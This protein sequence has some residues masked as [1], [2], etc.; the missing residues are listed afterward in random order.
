MALP[1]SLSYIGVFRRNGRSAMR[2]ASGPSGVLSRGV[3]RRRKRGMGRSRRDSRTARTCSGVSTCAWGNIRVISTARNLGS[4]RGS[5]RFVLA[6]IKGQLRQEEW[7][8]GVNVRR[9][10]QKKPRGG[11]DLRRAIRYAI[12]SPSA[13]GTRQTQN[14]GNIK[15]D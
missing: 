7:R 1:L 14:C 3:R 15:D 4:G 9:R 2:A 8:R 13:T 11:R 10:R 6:C 12:L 5:A